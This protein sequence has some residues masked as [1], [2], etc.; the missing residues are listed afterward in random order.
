MRN[1]VMRRVV[2][3]AFGAFFFAAGH[4]ALG[5]LGVPGAIGTAEAQPHQPAKKPASPTPK[6]TASKPAKTAAEREPK[7]AKSKPQQVSG[8]AGRKAGTERADADPEIRASI[9]G[10]DPPEKRPEPPD[11]IYDAAKPPKKEGD[12]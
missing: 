1:E 10:E 9:A 7:T 11:S 6:P 8:K 5:A 4:V 12:A 3:G 2:V